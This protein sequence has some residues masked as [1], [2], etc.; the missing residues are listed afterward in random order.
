[1]KIKITSLILWM[2]K[3]RCQFL[4][5]FASSRGFGVELGFGTEPEPEPNPNPNPGSRTEPNPNPDFMRGP[6]PNPEFFN[7][8]P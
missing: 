5:F 3:S 7:P 4:R 6:N 8:E 1:M 2:F